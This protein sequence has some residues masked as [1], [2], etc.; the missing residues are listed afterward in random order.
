MINLRKLDHKILSV[1]P[2]LILHHKLVLARWQISGEHT[3]LVLDLPGAVDGHDVLK[4][5]GLYLV[6]ENRMPALEVFV[7]FV[8][9]AVVRG[10][11]D[12]QHSFF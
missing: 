2:L 11:Q 5:V 6:L 1:Q 8:D 7:Q 9:S 10:F 3:E 4:L 12:V